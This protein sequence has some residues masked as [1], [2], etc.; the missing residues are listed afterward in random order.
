[1]TVPTVRED[2]VKQILSYT[3]RWGDSHLSLSLWLRSAGCEES[4]IIDSSRAPHCSWTSITG[5][6]NVPQH[7]G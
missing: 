7:L 3:K 1:M 4:Q 2:V 6:T 5:R